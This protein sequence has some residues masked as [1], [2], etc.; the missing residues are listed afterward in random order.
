M[1]LKRDSLHYYLPAVLSQEASQVSEESKSDLRAFVNDSGESSAEAVT[2]H[3][4]S[5]VTMDGSTVQDARAQFVNSDSQVPEQDDRLQEWADL[6]TFCNGEDDSRGV[7]DLAS[8]LRDPAANDFVELPESPHEETMEAPKAQSLTAID[9]SSLTSSFRGLGSLLQKFL[10]LGA[11]TAREQYEATPSISSFDSSMSASSMHRT[12][13]IDAADSTDHTAELEDTQTLHP[14]AHSADERSVDAS[15]GEQQSESSSSQPVMHLRGGASNETEFSTHARHIRDE[16]EVSSTDSEGNPPH[17]PAIA[18]DIAFERA[19]YLRRK[20]AHC[21]LRPSIS[22]LLEVSRRPSQISFRIDRASSSDG[23]RPLEEEK[24]KPTG[25]LFPDFTQPS[26]ASLAKEFADAESITFDDFVRQGDPEDLETANHQPLPPKDV[27]IPEWTFD[28]NDDSEPRT[29]RV[30]RLKQFFHRTHPRPCRKTEKV[31]WEDGERAM[32]LFGETGSV[33]VKTVP[34]PSRPTFV[35]RVT[36]LGLGRG[37]SREGLVASGEGGAG[38]SS[39]S[40]GG[41][42]PLTPFQ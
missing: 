29:D 37:L 23:N 16:D 25:S 36:R 26:P 3:K 40:E 38:E 13:S 11:V 1:L 30:T 2:V 21:D 19:N 12:D 39:D 7:A 4:S 22:S 42:V 35:R 41:G 18:L 31:R 34:A 14:K 15:H 32:Q 28:P 9:A 24:T 20:K 5:L 27:Y 10:L 33:T 8:G 17:D 6:F